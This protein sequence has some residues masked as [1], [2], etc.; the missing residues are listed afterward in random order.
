MKFNE[1]FAEYLDYLDLEGG[2]FKHLQTV[3]SRLRSFVLPSETYQRDYRD[4]ELT[5]ITK[6]DILEFFRLMK[7]AGKAEATWAAHRATQQ[8]FWNWCIRCGY[9]ET[10][11]A[12]GLPK[13]SLRPVIRRAAPAHDV[14]TVVSHIYDF[15]AH[16]NWNPRDIRDA[17]LISLIA[18][19]GARLGE[20]ADIRRDRIMR[21]LERPNVLGNGFR[22]FHVPTKG[23]TGSKSIRFYEMSY[24]L[25]HR[26]LNTTKHL[27]AEFVFCSLS[28]GK[29]L[30]VNSA[31]KAF[32][33]ACNYFDVPVFRAQALRKRNVTDVIS[34]TGDWKKG[35]LYAGHS[36]PEVTMLHYNDFELEALDRIGA[37][38]ASRRY[39]NANVEFDMRRLFGVNNLGTKSSS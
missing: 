19:S 38:M 18:D 17:L 23:K 21:A 3:R 5:D 25:A 20:V 26:W 36:S 24:D 6:Q 15:A 34:Q 30:H 12:S 14:N 2:S 4:V 39:E 7:Q 37:E 32:I 35:Q 13:W 29:Q 9:V 28:T 33:R 1:A 10:S 31:A 16:R 27:N 11:P 22:V 8:A